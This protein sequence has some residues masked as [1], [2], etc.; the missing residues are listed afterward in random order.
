MRRVVHRANHEPERGFSLVE[1]M[2]ALAIT[3][4]VLASVFSMLNRGQRTFSREP[5]VADLNQNARAGLDRISRDLTMA[6][7]KTPG[8]SAILWDDGGGLTPDE[9]TIIYADPDIPVSEPLKCGQAGQGGGG[10]PCNTINMSSTL[11][12]DPETMDPRPADPELAYEEG[13]ILFA[14]ETGD[15]NDDNLVGIYPFELTQPP[16]LTSA[17]GSP[18]L[19]I[20]HN[21]GKDTTGIN[22][23]NGFNQQV[24][25][26]C[27]VVGFFRVVQYRV[28]PLPATPTPALERRDLSNAEPW[29]PVARNIENLQF[30][31]ATAVGNFADVPVPPRAD[32]PLSWINRVKATVAGRT[33]SKNLEGGTAGVFSPEDTHLRK[34]FSTAMSLRNL[35]F[36]A[37]IDSDGQKYN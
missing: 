4:I 19:Q 16:S 17:G 20:N 32:E 13:M 26:D 11:N 14:L 21:P 30:Q 18:T 15:C 22:H 33:E 31:Y 27:A 23:P 37:G 28:N 29:I 9:I 6:G 2:V 34:T 36:R 25:P 12:L 35:S 1:M 7:Y 5:E 8:A 24:H 3:L 10:G